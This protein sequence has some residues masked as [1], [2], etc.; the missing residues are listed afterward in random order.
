MVLVALAVRNRRASAAADLS[1][2]R[3]L[4]EQ[5]EVK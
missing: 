3:A 4:V 2:L 5:A 1:R